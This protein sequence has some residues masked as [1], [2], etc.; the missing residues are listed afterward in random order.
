M[1]TPFGGAQEFLKQLARY[2]VWNG[3][4]VVHELDPQVTHIFILDPRR[5]ET[6]TFDLEDIANF[7]KTFPEV[8]VIHRMNNCDQK[9]TAGGGEVAADALLDDLMLEAARLADCTVF[10]SEWLRDYF[11]ERGFD[12]EW[13]HTVIQN[14]ANDDIFYVKNEQVERPETIRLVTHHWSSNWLK[15]YRVYEEVDRMIADGELGGFEL[16]VIGRQPHEIEWRSADVRPPASGEQLANQLREHDIYLTASLW[17]PGG[18]HFIEGLQCGLPVV[19][20][21]DGGGIPEVARIA[22]AGF[23]TDVKTALLEARDRYEELKKKVYRDKPSGQR[24]V[25]EFGKLIFGEANIS[26]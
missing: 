20:H 21:E 15:G 18:M 1:R 2:I 11:Y 14:A 3:G 22:G 23:R 6:Y 26:S 5:I 19:F 9:Y 17:E 8:K 25:Y 7:K 13:S 16:T 10:I 4:E 12:R 24:L